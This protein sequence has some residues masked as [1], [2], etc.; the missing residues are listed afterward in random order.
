MIIATNNPQTV[1]TS[2]TLLKFSLSTSK[3]PE[4]A[5]RVENMSRPY[6]NIRD[7]DSRRAGDVMIF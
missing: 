6:A 4:G 3:V 7:V 2:C 5:I 1:K